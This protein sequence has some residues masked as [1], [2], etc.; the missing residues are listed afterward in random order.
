MIN[1]EINLSQFFVIALINFFFGWAWYSPLLFAKPWMKALKINPERMMSK[2]SKEKMPKL[3]AGA[4]ISTFA[5]SFVLQVL[6]HSMGAQDFVHGAMI[7]V[8][9]WLG[10]AL[11]SSLGT[12]W[13]G[14]SAIVVVINN[15]LFIVSY[16]IFGGLLAVWH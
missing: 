3:F 8:L 2:E 16:A 9:A 12:L 7:G 6:V 4:I 10:F 14:R 1:F 15:G 11:T 5:F 13:E